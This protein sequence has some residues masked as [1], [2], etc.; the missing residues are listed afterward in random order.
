M[1]F[2]L[3]SKKTKAKRFLTVDIEELIG[4]FAENKDSINDDT[5]KVKCWCPYCTEYGGEP[6]SKV[7]LTVYMDSLSF[8]CFRCHTAGIDKSIAVSRDKV[9]EMKEKRRINGIFSEREEI[10]LPNLDLS[11]LSLIRKDEYIK[12]FVNNRSYKY[13]PKLD[14]WGLREISLMGRKGIIFPFYYDGLL[15]NYQVRYLKSNSKAEIKYYTNEGHKLPWF[16]QGFDS[17]RDYSS[18]TLV[19]GVFDATAAELFGLPEPMAVLGSS[20][21][22]HVIKFITKVLKP[23]VIIY[24]FDNMELNLYIKKQFSKYHHESLFINTKDEDLDELLR[25]NRFPKIYSHNEYIEKRSSNNMDKLISE[26]LKDGGI[27]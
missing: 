26:F 5:V 24:A 13:I 14:L 1:K 27:K 12:Y 21:V 22:D 17:S 10:V 18:I 23:E 8:W 16:P 3:S 4:E 6:N 25:S 7:T 15:I 20:L 9:G 2:T 11:H 19:E